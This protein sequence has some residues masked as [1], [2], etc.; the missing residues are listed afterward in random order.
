[1]H[2]PQFTRRVRFDGRQFGEPIGLQD[3]PSD[4]YLA[5][6]TIGKYWQRNPRGRS[7]TKYARSKVPINLRRTWTTATLLICSLI[8]ACGIDTSSDVANQWPQGRSIP[9]KVTDNLILSIPLAYERFAISGHPAAYSP[10]A[11]VRPVESAQ[12]AFDFFLPDFSG[13]TRQRFEENFDT[14]EVQV[15]YL[16]AS[17][18]QPSDGGVPNNYPPNVLANVLRDLADPNDFQDM[19]G[20]RCYKGRILKSRAFCYGKRGEQDGEG[21]LLDVMIPPFGPGLVN[22]QMHARYFAKRYGGVELA[23]RTNTKNLPRWHEIDAQIWKFIDTW[24]IA[25]AKSA[26]PEH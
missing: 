3:S 23:W 11:P 13:Y 16:V 18:P 10:A 4:A 26:G 20:L 24:N 8:G 21:I 19:Y 7:H 22:P 25:E 15:A 1:M 9:F 14:N 5:L 12:V 2:A 17:N 6:W